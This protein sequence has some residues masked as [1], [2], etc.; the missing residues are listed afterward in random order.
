MHIRDLHW[1]R[2]NIAI[3]RMQQL[4]Y[5]TTIP[6][7][8]CCITSLDIS[9]LD[10]RSCGVDSILRAEGLLFRNGKV[11]PYSFETYDFESTDFFQRHASSIFL[12]DG[13]LHISGE[14]EEMEINTVLRNLDTC[15]G[16]FPELRPAASMNVERSPL[17]YLKMQKLLEDAKKAELNAKIDSIL[18]KRKEHPTPQNAAETQKDELDR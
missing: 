9:I 4:L 15:A 17:E 1:F 18:A 13:K 11:E 6:E 7:G 12:S 3:P 14:L 8:Y 10:G 5:N 16:L 2:D